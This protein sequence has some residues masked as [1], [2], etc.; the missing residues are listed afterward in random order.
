MFLWRR[1]TFKNKIDF[2]TLATKSRDSSNAF[3]ALLFF[4]KISGGGSMQAFIHGA[5]GFVVGV[6]ATIIATAYFKFKNNK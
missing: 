2:K 4:V 5:V 3:S 1:N 6:A